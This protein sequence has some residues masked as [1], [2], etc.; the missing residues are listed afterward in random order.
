MPKRYWFKHRAPPAWAVNPKPENAVER[1]ALA[2]RQNPSRNLLDELLDPLRLQGALN[3]DAQSS[4]I[5][6]ALGGRLPVRAP[7]W[8]TAEELCALWPLVCRGLLKMGKTPRITPEDM[9]RK[10]ARY[11]V[12]VVRNADEAAGFMWKGR[13]RLYWFTTVPATGI[14]PISQETFEA[15]M[16]ASFGNL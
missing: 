10:L 2:I 7:P 15:V 13:R 11:K 14:R 6:A 3:P 12:P 9:A 4:G 1:L 5:L 16:R 8:H